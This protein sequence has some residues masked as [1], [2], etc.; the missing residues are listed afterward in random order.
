MGIFSTCN[1][2]TEKK[3]ETS[4][5]KE[6]T[7]KKNSGKQMN[8]V[9]EQMKLLGGMFSTMDSGDE[10]NPFAGSNNYL[11]VVDKMDVPE[12]TKNYLCEQYKLY[13]MSLDPKKKDS[14]KLMV[15]KMLN[16]LINEGQEELNNN[17]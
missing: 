12:E 9:D 11:E 15:D 14:L 17:N 5:Q 10:V 1:A 7:H 3:L 2:Q 8:L 13:N 4:K 16:D 6:Q